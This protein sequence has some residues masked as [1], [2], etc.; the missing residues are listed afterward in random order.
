VAYEQS[1]P[2]V[3]RDYVYARPITEKTHQ[4]STSAL[5]SKRMTDD[6]YERG[7]GKKINWLLPRLFF[8]MMG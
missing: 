3:Y 1:P 2:E 7:A 8:L 5:P 4:S 6:Q